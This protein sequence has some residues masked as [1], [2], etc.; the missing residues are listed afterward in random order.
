MNRLVILGAGTPTP[1]P[2]R[3]GS[4]YVLQLGDECILVDCGP[5]TTYKMV[6]AGLFPAQVNSLFFTHHHSDHNADYPCFFLCRW[7]QSAGRFPD[8]EIFGPDKTKKITE[9]LFG[10]NGAYIYDLKARIHWTSSR[11]VYVN[12]GGK[13]PRAM[14]ALKVREV[15]PG[16]VIR[17]KNW[18]ATVAAAIHAQPWLDCVAYRFDSRAG[19]VVM[20]GD[21]EICDSVIELARGADLLVCMCWNIH[22]RMV[23][24][25][26][27][28]G[29]CSTRTAAVLAQEAGVKKLVLTHAGPYL[30]RPD[31][32]KKGLAQARKIFK[33]EVVFAD[34]GMSVTW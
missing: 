28:A 34:E 26:E 14:P 7:D 2:D 33:G 6:K 12:R 5:A 18:K 9:R 29:Q 16:D 30:A 8:L 20:S 22:E 4:S 21:T 32:R 10:A 13:L 31:N 19:S 23:A 24:E 15:K 3:F 25:G 11:H 1:T 17:R 27:S